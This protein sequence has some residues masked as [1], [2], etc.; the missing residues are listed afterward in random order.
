[1]E[2]NIYIYALTDPRTGIVRYIGASK[3]PQK[4]LQQHLCNNDGASSILKEDWINELKKSQLKPLLIILEEIKSIDQKES[5]TKW[6]LFY[7]DKVKLTNI[8]DG[9]GKP[10]SK[11]V[12]RL[13]KKRKKILKEEQQYLINYLRPKKQLVPTILL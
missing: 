4:R 12:S 2:D 13:R 11:D 9:Y 10:L 7:R 8:T 1:M 6:I 3:N 5:E